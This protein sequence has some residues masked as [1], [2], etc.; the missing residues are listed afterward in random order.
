MDKEKKF[1]SHAFTVC[2]CVRVGTH[3]SRMNREICNEIKCAHNENETMR[4]QKQIAIN[5]DEKK[6]ILTKLL[7][8]FFFFCFFSCVD[9]DSFY[10]YNEKRK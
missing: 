8:F 5:A 3:Q 6:K 10:V 2:R 1:S 9:D 4:K 7:L